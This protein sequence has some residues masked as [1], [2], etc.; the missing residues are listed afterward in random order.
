M[1]WTLSVLYGVMI[2]GDQI[3][4]VFAADG[5]LSRQVSAFKPREAQTE[6]A[7]AI[8]QTMETGGMLVVEAGTGV[9]KTFAYLVPALLSG[10]RVLI[11][12]ATKTL[13]DQLFSR[14]LPGLVRAL[15][16]PI[17]M[18]L[19]KGRGSYLC[20]HRLDYARFDLG[21]DDRGAIKTLADLEFWA[22]TTQ[23][24]DLAELPGLDERSKVIPMVT[25]TRENCLGA[26][27][28]QFQRCF[29]NVARREA[30]MAEVVVINHHLF[31]ADLVVRESG[32]AELLPSVQTVI[33]DEAHQLNEIGVQF[34]GQQLTTGQLLEFSR[35][36]STTG[37][38]H[39]RGVC[40]WQAL[41]ADIEYAA[42]DLRMVVGGL[43]CGVRLHWSGPV[44]DQVDASD[45]C[46]AM[47]RLNV[48]FRHTNEALNIVMGTSPDLQ[49]LHERVQSLLACLASFRDVSDARFARWIDVGLHLKLVVSPLS[50]AHAMQMQ[51]TG[52]NS[53]SSLRRS[54]IF[55]SATLG[56][57]PKLRW[58]T[59]PCGLSEAQV[60]RLASPFDYPKQAALYVPANFL[61]P[62]DAAHSL[63]VAQLVAE[64]ARAIGGRTLV[65]TTTLR[66]LKEISDRLK[67]IFEKAPN[68][69]VWAQGQLSKRE[70]LERLRLGD[71]GG[72]SGCIL[73]A[74]ASFW[75]GVDVPGDALQLVVMDKLPFPPP[76]DSLVQAHSRYWE[77]AGK[78]AFNN[79]S[80]PEAALVLKQ[81]AG[82]L[83]RSETDRGILVVC[84]S[85]LAAPGYGKR[86]IKAL[87]PMRRIT[88]NDEWQSAL[89]FLTK[90][91]TMDQS[92][93]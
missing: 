26:G 60:L 15:G 56:D 49:R 5:L 83:I 44:P 17:R 90:P 9:G 13:Q 72:R 54:W 36:L 65:L 79:Y 16:I 6:M 88:T 53:E 68:L 27:C 74:S 78:S 18:A 80:M 82:R 87:P 69:E 64:G 76:D 43:G 61:N 45:W 20:L 55:T 37:L 58:F 21:Q 42:R 77:R 70:L 3:A 12:T 50:I 11:S 40:D 22:L 33:F 31:F 48:V 66:A 4:G 46:E 1:F 32:M 25:S 10:S 59:E 84:D 39:A 35:E 93:F 14:D 41:A 47:G 7:L 86:L 63:Q 51:F 8:A 34:L 52:T 75:E 62:G 81:G 85:R 2:L 29:V 73:V 28:P 71:T 57:D 19:L 38:Q 89:A 67:L 24:G 91:S 30:L 92:Y 23:T